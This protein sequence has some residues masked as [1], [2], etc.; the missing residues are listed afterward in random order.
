MLK[1]IIL[2]AFFALTSIAIYS[3]RPSIELT[4]TAI[5]SADHLQLDSIKVMN[6]TQAHQVGTYQL[7]KNL[8]YWKGL[9]TVN[10]EL[11]TRCGILLMTAHGNSR[12]MMQV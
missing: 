5:D 4:F 6:R 7:M 10:L 3:Q 12:V 11:G 2:F 1:K 9:L 8:K